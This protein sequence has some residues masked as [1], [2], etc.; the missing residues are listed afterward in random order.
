MADADSPGGV[1]GLSYAEITS[2]R[3]PAEWIMN[4]LNLSVPRLR[5]PLP[6]DAKERSK[7]IEASLLQHNFKVYFDGGSEARSALWDAYHDA[8]PDEFDEIFNN[9]EYLL[10]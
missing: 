3:Q 9:E 6:F 5:D 4:D 7:L 8:N 2:A 1:Y 10:Q